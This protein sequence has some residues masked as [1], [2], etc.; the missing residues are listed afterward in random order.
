MGKT[1][2]S[3]KSGLDVFGRF[4]PLRLCGV[5]IIATVG[6]T[7]PASTGSDGSSPFPSPDLSM[8]AD[9]A[10]AVDQAPPPGSDLSGDLASTTPDIASSMPDLVPLPPDL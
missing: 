4:M 6:C 7:P 9:S 5:A 2:G 3:R 1:T 10:I 8:P